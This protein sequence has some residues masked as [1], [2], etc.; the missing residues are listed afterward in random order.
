MEQNE[1]EPTPL[2]LVLQ[3]LGAKNTVVQETLAKLSDAGIKVSR[4]TIYQAIAGSNTRPEV[5]ETFM[6]VAEAEFTRRRELAER[7]RQLIAEA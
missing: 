1:K 3:K 7:A 2:Q 4:S 5:A 6:Q